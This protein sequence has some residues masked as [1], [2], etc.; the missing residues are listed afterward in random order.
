MQSLSNALWHV[1]PVQHQVQQIQDDTASDVSVNIDTLLHPIVA[2]RVRPELIF[3]D[4][5]NGSQHETLVDLNTVILGIKD[6]Q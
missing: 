3:N 1:Y 4:T 2:E 5:I 6:R